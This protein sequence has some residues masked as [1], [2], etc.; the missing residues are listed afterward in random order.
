MDNK[1]TFRH[2]NKNLLVKLFDTIYNQFENQIGKNC[3]NFDEGYFPD[4]FKEKTRFPS[5]ELVCPAVIVGEILMMTV[6]V[7][8]ITVELENI[9]KK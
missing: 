2:E 5:L 4:N 3:V 1:I 8:G 7:P 9:I 6:K